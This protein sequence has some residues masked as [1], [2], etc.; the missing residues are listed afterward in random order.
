MDHVD[1]WGW[2]AGKEK[3]NEEARNLWKTGVPY[4]LS[5]VCTLA[6][7]LQVFNLHRTITECVATRVLNHVRNHKRH[8][9]PHPSLIEGKFLIA[10]A[11]KNGAGPWNIKRL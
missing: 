6:K 3:Y 8:L 9:F 1:V 10:A 11:A 2:A 7:V 4:L 5:R